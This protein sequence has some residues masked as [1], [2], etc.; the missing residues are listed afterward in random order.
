MIV[1][2]HSGGQGFLVH[3]LA[4]PEEGRRLFAQSVEIHAFPEY[5]RF[6]DPGDAGLTQTPV[7][8]ASLNEVLQGRE[9]MWRRWLSSDMLQLQ[10][11]WK[12]VPA[13]APHTLHEIA[14]FYLP[15]IPV[16]LNVSGD[17]A[18]RLRASAGISK[19]IPGV[20]E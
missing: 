11:W 9:A 17:F 1:R 15:S 6:V 16:D 14:Q 18:K 13:Q 5:F 19:D 7:T 12:Q 3:V 2:P 10:A 4:M 20:S 8:A